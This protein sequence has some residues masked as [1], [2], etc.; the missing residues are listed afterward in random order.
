MGGGT[1]GGRPRHAVPEKAVSAT[2]RAVRPARVGAGP[3]RQRRA[4][5]TRCDLLG[6][7]SLGGVRQVVNK[8]EEFQ[9]E[10]ATNI[11][12]LGQAHELQSLARRMLEEMTRFKYPSN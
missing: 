6:D 10:V 8:I 1:R 4:R 2:P 3:D 11:E 7:C 12:R 9:R 5:R